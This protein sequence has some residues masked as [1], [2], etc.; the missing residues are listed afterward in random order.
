MST[1]VKPWLQFSGDEDDF[2]FWSEK[3]EAFMH[4]KK[5]RPILNGTGG[6]DDAKYNIWAY[7]VQCLDK[8]SVMM[9]KGEHKGN[10]P[11]AWG[12]LKA[13]YSS[14]ETPRVMT[15]LERF[16]TLVLGPDEQMVEYLIRA[17]ELSN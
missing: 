10:G 6:D 1:D 3:F 11:A 17:E 5:L 2:P 8:R 4:T 15:L 14:T 13:Y 16:T 12:A 7:L 9:V